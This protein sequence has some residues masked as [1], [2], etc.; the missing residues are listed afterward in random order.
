MQCWMPLRY[1]LSELSFLHVY[2]IWS[3]FKIFSILCDQTFPFIVSKTV[4]FFIQGIPQAH[5]TMDAQVMS[6]DPE[7]MF[8]LKYFKMSSKSDLYIILLI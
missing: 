5:E 2:D 6:W 7:E 8:W 4:I 3:F 1:F